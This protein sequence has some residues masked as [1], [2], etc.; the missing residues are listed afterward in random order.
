MYPFEEIE[1]KELQ[2]STAQKRYLVCQGSNYF[3]ANQMMV[4]LMA[5]LAKV[6]NVE[7]AA[8]MFVEAIGDAYSIDSIIDYVNTKLIPRFSTADS[9]Q[10]KK[11]FLYQVELLKA[12]TVNKI[13]KLTGIMF[14]KPLLISITVVASILDILF[15]V[16]TPHLLSYTGGSNIYIVLGLFVC[17]CL[18]SFFHEL[19]H[20]SACSYYGVKHGGIGIGLYLTFPVL[21]TDVN[22]A[23]RLPRTRRCV[24]NYAG[25][26]FQC[27]IAILL[28]V[29]FYIT[30]LPFLKYLLLMMNMGFAFVLNPFFKFDG[31]WLASDI[32][33]VPNLRKRSNEAFI[34]SIR[35]LLRRPTPKPYIFS[36]KKWVMALFTAYTLFTTA[37]MGYFFFYVLPLFVYNFVQ[38]FPHD[39]ERLAMYLSAGVE[40]PFSLLRNIVS[41]GLFMA[42]IVIMIATPLYK[43]IANGRRYK[44]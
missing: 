18:S 25:V 40:M 16:Y 12:E 33:G 34:Y 38:T 43:R 7:E 14:H 42:F 1:I 22:N 10:S 9:E 21:Y 20:A 29:A 26:Y 3:E 27:I 8:R 5:C 6:D 31:Y 24:V 19:G 35:R 39:I 23:W 30:G 44:K 17:I 15:L 32:L 13:T 28:I 2:C 36:L 37:F 11:K 41:Q 4:D